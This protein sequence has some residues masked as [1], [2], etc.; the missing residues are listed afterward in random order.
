MMSGG[1]YDPRIP[2]RHGVNGA[3]GLCLRSTDPSVIENYG[4]GPFNPPFGNGGI[5]LGCVANS[6]ISG[7]PAAY[8]INATAAHPEIDS[9]FQNAGQTLVGGP[10]VYGS[11][12]V[13]TT[14][15]QPG[16]A[17]SLTYLNAATNLNE[18]LAGKLSVSVCVEE[19]S[20]DFGD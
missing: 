10:Y 15:L 14:D 9:E 18:P 5:P 19:G 1:F 6:R 13:V 4:N 11:R 20:R 7:M 3:D 12:L 17:N 16:G 8:A 2:N